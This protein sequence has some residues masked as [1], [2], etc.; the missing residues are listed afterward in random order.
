MRCTCPL[1][2]AERTQKTPPKRRGFV[3]TAN[4]RSVARIAGAH[5]A[6]VG[7][8]VAPCAV[9]IHLSAIWVGLVVRSNVGALLGDV[10]LHVVAVWI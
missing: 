6:G 5:L 3:L 4:H 8:H 2:G 1:S 7:V 10:R 9:V